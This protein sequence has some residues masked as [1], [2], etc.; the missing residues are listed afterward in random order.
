MRKK[1]VLIFFAVLCTASLAFPTDIEKIEPGNWWT[2]MKDSKLELLV[3]GKDL[4]GTSVTIEAE[5]VEVV[6]VENADSP[7]YLFVTLDIGKDQKAGKIKLSFKKGK[8]FQ[9]ISYELKER[10]EN[11]AIRKGF[12]QSDVFLSDYAGSFCKR[13]YF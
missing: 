7:D 9:K 6:A 11:S 12:D 2:G 4:D 13:G 5:D 1:L 8:F 10:S 3:Y